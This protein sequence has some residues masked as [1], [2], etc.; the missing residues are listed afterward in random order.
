MEKVFLP[1]MSAMDTALLLL[2][3]T[4]DAKAELMSDAARARC[5][6]KCI[7]VVWVRHGRGEGALCS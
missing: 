3:S 2:I 1:L 7:L 4:G 6:L 5:E